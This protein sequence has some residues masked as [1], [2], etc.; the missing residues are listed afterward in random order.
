[1][2]IITLCTIISC[3]IEQCAGS[4]IYTLS[5]ATGCCP[6]ASR[7]GSLVFAQR[8]RAPIRISCNALQYDCKE[9]YQTRDMRNDEQTEE[10][11]FHCRANESMWAAAVQH[12]QHHM[13]HEDEGAAREDM[14]TQTD[15]P[16]VLY[17]VQENNA[18]WFINYEWIPLGSS[19]QWAKFINYF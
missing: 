6:A 18:S 1:M 10:H 3:N 12:P 16:M 15:K 4:I 5:D 13:K 19:T 11:M 14:R 17:I 9:V 7:V 8:H 2:I